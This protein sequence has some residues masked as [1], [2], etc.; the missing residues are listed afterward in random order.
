[1]PIT[2]TMLGQLSLLLMTI[3]FAALLAT[4]A[5]LV[6]LI[7]NSRSFATGVSATEEVRLAA[8]R[9]LSLLQDAETGQRGYLLTQNSAYLQPYHDAIEGLPRELPRL[10]RMV[11]ATGGDTGAIRRLHDLAGAKMD[12]LAETLA[13][14]ELGD[15][16]GALAV[17]R[18][19]R[20]K[21]A[22]DAIR[23]S[24]ARIEAQSA[25]EV[26]A[27]SAALNRNGRLLL[28]GAAAAFLLILAVTIGA[29]LLAWRY[30]I[31]LETAQAAIAAANSSLEARVAER[32]AAL[33]AA[34]EEVQRFAYIV[35][36]DLR[37]PLVNIMGFTAEL[38]AS[39]EP[40]A[41]LVARLEGEAPALLASDARLAVTEDIPEALGFIRSSTQ[42]MDRLIN[43]I[44]RLSREGRRMLQ[45]EQVALDGVIGAIAGALQHQ[46]EAA[47]ARLEVAPGLPVLR[48]DRLA[49][50]QIFGNLLDNAVKY[51]DPSRPGRIA[52]RGRRT[53]THAVIEVED[54]G[55]GIDPRDH[56]R[57]FELFR[58]SGRQDRPG[59][60]IGLAHVRALARR[61][62]GDVECRSAPGLGSTFRVTLALTAPASAPASEDSPA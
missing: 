57:I 43:A 42:R 24:V 1:M 27:R 56:G 34:N 10:E 36:H 40:L 38:Q 22:M 2:K 25:Q 19:D 32:T 18:T 44:L 62:G 41:A 29:A 49:V 46:L 35:S 5:G 7:E 4:G 55:R 50:E 47:G 20:G 21:V 33:A 16:Q 11:T 60:G 28:I 3:G 51:L 13:R 30:T 31:V 52:V 53:A 54:N 15:L 17:V 23:Q 39:I 59:E 58:R 61:L 14:A 9:V 26:A 37:S 12:E 8:S 48:T 6:W 45:P